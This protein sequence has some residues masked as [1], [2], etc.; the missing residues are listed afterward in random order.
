HPSDFVLV[1]C[2]FGFGLSVVPVTAAILGAVAPAFHGV[3]ASLT[4]AARMVGMLTGLSLLT[5]IGLHHFYATQ[6]T[7]PSPSALCPTTPLSCPA[8][9]TLETA[10]VVDE[11]HVIFVG[12]AMCALLA[13]L[14]AVALLR[15]DRVVP[16]RL[17]LGSL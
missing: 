13:A 1:A 11:L 3:A 9:N 8:Y 5:A 10:A 7:L 12:A 2:G 16:K 4:V 6:A 15:R 14:V 17:A